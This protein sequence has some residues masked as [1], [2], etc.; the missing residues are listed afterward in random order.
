MIRTVVY[1]LLAL[2]LGIGL[3]EAGFPQQRTSIQ[4]LAVAPGTDPLQADQKLLDYLRRKVPVSFERQNMDYDA[5][6]QTL[7]EWDGKKQGPLMAR[8]TP[9]VFVVAEMLGAEMDILGTYVSK[10][11]N[12]T[13]QDSY[14][15]VHKSLGYKK[16]EDLKDFVRHL[17]NQQAQA[18][19]F[20]K[21]LKQR[22]TPA[23]F[24]YHNKY[25]T[26]SH[27][28]PS[29]FFRSKGIFSLLNPP[30]SQ[31]KFIT[32]HSLQPENARSASDLIQLILDRQ[33]EFAAVRE[34]VKIKFQNTPDLKFIKMP[35][36]SPNDLLVVIKPFSPQVREQIL[37]NIRKMEI[38]DLNEGDILKWEDFNASPK[39]R[40]SLAT[41]RY[42]A[43]TTPHPVVINIRKS[44]K[45]DSGI[46]EKHLEAARQ[47]VRFS[48]TEMVLF[49]EDFHSA[50]DVLWSLEKSH[51]D[52]IL[53]TSTIMDSGLTQE[54]TVSF[55]K[56]DMESLAAR[57]SWVID[58]KMHRIRYVWPYD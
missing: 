6:I 24:V 58:H 30:K 40:K 20:I 11:S 33:A 7:L 52:S 53:L 47:A 56:N 22:E 4:F 26:S 36:T 25:S 8:V 23:R 49:D 45:P 1:L 46:D 51:D 29:L 54:F 17:G 10:N 37:E 9:Y 48:G 19:D 5:A 27:F 12:R 18:E 43:K 42:Q 31:Q 35:Y 15:V 39:A 2:V 38:A 41:L 55:R 32:I 57:I 3:P 14:F 44:Q 21:R 34:S 50:F 13:V 28:L 16:T